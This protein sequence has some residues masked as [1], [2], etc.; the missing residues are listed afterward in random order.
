VIIDLGS[1]AG[2]SKKMSFDVVVE[3]KKLVAATQKTITIVRNIGR[4]EVKEVSADSS[5]AEVKDGR[6]AIKEGMK[7][8][9]K[10][11]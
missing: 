11:D 9:S 4:V 7:I 2:V 8:V 6:D 3:E 10:K 5:V 1:E